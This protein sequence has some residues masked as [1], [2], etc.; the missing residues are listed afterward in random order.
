[1]TVT[2]RTRFEVFRR[3]NFT[4]QYC[5]AKPPECELQVDHVMPKALGGDDTPG[6]LVTACHD[7]NIGKSSINP[8]SPL[9]QGLSEKAAS[10]ALA[11]QDK[12]TRFRADLESLDDYCDAFLAEWNEWK[13]SRTGER[14]ELP[15]EWKSSLFRWKQMGVP[16]SIFPIVVPNAMSKQ[17]IPSSGTF[18]YMSGIIWNMVNE[19]E[20]D[21]SVTEETCAVYTNADMSEETFRAFYKGRDSGA[22]EAINVLSA[23]GMRSQLEKIGFIFDEDGKYVSRQGEHSD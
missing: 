12:M 22:T 21:Y 10:Y 3:D 13:N 23:H 18:R 14:V 8:D 7:C 15:P 1:M 19:R 16:E 5:G 17:N 2:K 11:M 9:V 20:I 4:C 6:N